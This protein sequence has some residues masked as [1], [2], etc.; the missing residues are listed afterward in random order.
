L[1]GLGFA[2][3]KMGRPEEGLRFVD[4][5][6]SLR[7]D[8]AD[9]HYRRGYLLCWLDRLTEALA[10]FEQILAVDPNHQDARCD[11]SLVLLA[12]GDYAEGFQQYESRWLTRGAASRPP[13]EAPLWLGLNSLEGKTILVFSEQGLGDVLQ[14]SRYAALLAHR[15]AAVILRVP[16]PLVQLM[17]SLSGAV[18]VIGEAE[19][20]PA[21][22]FQCPLLSLPL[23]FAT[24]LET[25]P[26]QVP[27]LHCAP[28]DAARWAAALG[29]KCKPRIG[30][31]WAGR[32]VAPLT[33]VRDVALEAL[34]P[35][36]ELDAQFISLQQT[37]PERDRALL[38]SLTLARHGEELRDFA[39]CA[40]LIENLDLVISVDTA[41]VH[42]AGALGKPVWLMNRK[43]SCWR[44]LRG[45]D[46]SPW[47]PTLRLFRQQQLHD[48]TGVVR[49]VVSALR[50]WL[51]A[52]Q[53]AAVIS[54]RPVK[55]KSRQQAVG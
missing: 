17:R 5:A 27:Y 7:P 2:L 25:I 53:A 42:L 14:F 41:V 37:V 34:R 20:L 11:R 40:G 51:A 52:A 23:A 15:A 21:H 50:Q 45:R 16:E 55:H 35:L 10:T 46:D 36:L 54:A 28:Q 29:P 30:I 8:Y 44:W 31:A 13:T 6:L 19:P 39:D 22:D 3:G 49:D 24:R 12:R 26:A 47:Y 33:R 43:A 38:E 9:A 1:C 4:R 18:R 32:Q 48:W